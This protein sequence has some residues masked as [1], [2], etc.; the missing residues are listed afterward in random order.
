MSIFFSE[1][2]SD[3]DVRLVGGPTPEGQVPLMGRIE[4]C[5]NEAYGTVCDSGFGR[6]EASVVC[7][8]LGFSRIRKHHS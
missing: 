5:I 1:I 6:E 2:C 4:V 8:Q 3:G 7:G